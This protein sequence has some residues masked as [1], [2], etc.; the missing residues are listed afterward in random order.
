MEKS[1]K[2]L[3]D[4]S[5]WKADALCVLCY[6]RRRDDVLL[7]RKKRGFGAG[8]ISGPGGK[9]EPGETSLDA[10]IRE[11]QEELGVTPHH[12][13]HLGELH[14]Q[15]ADGFALQCAVFLATGCLGEPVETEEAAPLW[16]HV[17]ALPLDAMWADDRHW[18]PGLLEGKCF[19]A[20]FEFDGDRMLSR[21]VEWKSEENA[22]IL[23]KQ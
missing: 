1:K 20:Y 16:T 9:L 6:I 10:A 22:K 13:Q 5:V 21:Q 12:L 15:F 17:D 3:R 23:T 19:R 7:I 14:F 11:T 8:K 2:S 18:L 4:W